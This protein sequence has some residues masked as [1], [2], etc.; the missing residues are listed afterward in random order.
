MCIRDR[1][2]GS[3]EEEL[4]GNKVNQVVPEIT[5]PETERR[6]Y[7][8]KLAIGVLEKLDDKKVYSKRDMCD[9][10]ESGIPNHTPFDDDPKSSATNN[11]CSVDNYQSSHIFF[12]QQVHK[13]DRVEYKSCLLYTSRCV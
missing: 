13:K 10:I 1:K 12:Y 8:R 6:L 5:D 7:E 11:I 3:L 2:D 4:T 9:L